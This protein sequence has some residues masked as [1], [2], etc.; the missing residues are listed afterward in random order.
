MAVSEHGSF[1]RAAEQIHLTQP[2]IS[3]RIAA[4]ETE[5]GARLFDRIG[6]KVT[7][8]EAGQ[9]LADRA[10]A[11]L[12]AIEDVKTSINNLD[13]VVAGPLFIA[14]SHHIGLHRL[15]GALR[16]LN[17]NYS[18]VDLD[19]KFMDS[20]QACN[21]V[22]QGKIEL[23]VVTLPETADRHLYNEIIWQDPLRIVVAPDHELSLHKQATMEQLLAYPAVLPGTGTVTRE[24]I[25]KEFG[26]FAKN[27]NVAIA[28]NYL[29]VLKM[30]TIVG[31]GW[32]ALPKTMIDESLNVVQIKGVTI[33]R[34]LG[35]V[36]H[37]QRTLSNAAKLL[38]D[39][40][41]QTG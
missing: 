10:H 26:R 36:W 37:K 2:A 1:S 8:T 34:K 32:T 31:L 39:I 21:A 25:L 3:K 11:I 30:L 6:R 5:I 17:Q 18:E 29:E 15:P 24:I 28:T 7:R 27:I 41:K 40:I 19:L 12:L 9:T 23:A 22:T 38:I 33:E 20:E 4:L 35:I 14:T 16:F 13:G